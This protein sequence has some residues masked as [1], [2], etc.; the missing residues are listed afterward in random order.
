M[1]ILSKWKLESNSD[2]NGIPC[3]R[4]TTDEEI[5]CPCHDCLGKLIKKGIR[6]RFITRTKKGATEDD[7][8]PY[9][10]ICLLI[11][12]RKCKSCGT[13]HHELP[14]FIVP[15]K[16]LSLEIVEG[17]IKQPEKPTLIDEDTVKRLLA[18]WAMMAAYILRVAPSIKEKYE[19]TITPGKNLAEIVRALAHSHLWPGT[20]IQLTSAG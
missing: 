13:I 14:D 19:A 7:Y 20:R 8:F 17:S 16:R 10:K 9:E 15:Y 12:R 11:Q 18:W 5:P 3:F 1:I 6:T 4:V 2:V